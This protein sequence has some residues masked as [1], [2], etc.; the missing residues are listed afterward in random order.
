MLIP[1]SARRHRA[2]ES[3][4]LAPQLDK[5]RDGIESLESRLSVAKGHDTPPQ[6]DLAF[7]NSLSPQTAGDLA[8]IGILCFK[9]VP[10]PWSNLLSL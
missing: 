6:S 1:L 2:R 3:K 5:F 8:V 9:P 4:H 7:P 10:T